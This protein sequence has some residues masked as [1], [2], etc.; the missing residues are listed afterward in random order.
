MPRGDH[1]RRVD[2]ETSAITSKSIPM[3]NSA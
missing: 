3:Q 2:V 1:L